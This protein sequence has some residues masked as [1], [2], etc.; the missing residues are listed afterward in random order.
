MK[1]L[2]MLPIILSLLSCQSSEAQQP[3]IAIEDIEKMFASLKADGTYTDRLLLWTYFF[4]SDEKDR[5]ERIAEELK[6]KRFE[7][8]DI[9]QAEDSSYW[10]SLERKEIHN[11]ETLYKLNDELYSIADKYKV[12]Y[13]G[14]D[15]GNVIKGEAMERDTYV[16][17]EKF[18]TAGYL[19]DNLPYL[20][21]GNSSFDR[22]PHKKEFRYFIK[23]NTPFKKDEKML[24]PVDD[25]L[26]ELDHF[27]SSIEGY[28]TD[29]KVRN[30]YVFRETHNGIRNCYIVTNDKVG[31]I[32]VLNR[33]KEDKAN[34]KFE[35]EIQEDVEWE[36]YGTFREKINKHKE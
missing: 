16:V 10:L 7:L 25:E 18:V 20:L 35:F 6:L 24:L 14:F 36:L 2:V 13:D 28:L 1:V 8:A 29:N 23:I 31:A 33:I 19:A 17:P 27:E 12:T 34:R 11:A 5:F 3:K 30:Y 4:T 22:F 9:F 26:A 15:V 21:V 32:S